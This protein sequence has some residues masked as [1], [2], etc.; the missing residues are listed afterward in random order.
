MK[1]VEFI[2]PGPPVSKGRPKASIIAGNV[3]IRT[4]T[5]TV[6]YEAK[7]HACARVALA[8]FGP[9]DDG[10]LSITVVAVLARPKRLMRKKDPFD[11]IRCDK[12][13]QDAD[14]I[15][16]AVSDGTE[17][18]F[19]ANDSRIAEAHVSKWYAAKGEAPHTKVIVESLTPN[20]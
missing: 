9:L 11:R 18:T 4:P 1:R 7:V 15:L 5:K 3:H 16:K 13:P 2:V 10:P 19:Y 17:G 8:K 20:P 14:N 6:S 12:G